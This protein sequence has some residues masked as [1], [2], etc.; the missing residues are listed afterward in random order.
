MIEHDDVPVAVFIVALIV[1]SSVAFEVLTSVRVNG[2][3]PPEGCWTGIV[4]SCLA[5]LI[6]K[7]WITTWQCWI[8]LRTREFAEA[9]GFAEVRERRAAKTVTVEELAKIILEKDWLSKRM[10][11]MYCTQR[12]GRRKR[13]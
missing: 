2:V 6:V 3:K 4:S 10:D 1:F 9:K 13:V 12:V 8:C 7:V 11:S 5:A